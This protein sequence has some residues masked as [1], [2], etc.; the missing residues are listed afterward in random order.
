MKAGQSGNLEILRLLV[1]AG[2]ILDL[3]SKQGLTAL[4]YAVKNQNIPVAKELL[5]AGADRNARDKGGRTVV[6]LVGEQGCEEMVELFQQ[7]ALVSDTSDPF[8]QLLSTYFV[9]AEDSKASSELSPSSHESSPAASRTHTKQHLGPNT[10]PSAAPIP[11]QPL[12]KPQSDD[13]ST[14][15]DQLQKS[16]KRIADLETR[17]HDLTLQ[18]TMEPP[19]ASDLSYLDRGRL[20]EEF[21]KLKELKKKAERYAVEAKQTAQRLSAENFKLKEDLSRERHHNELTRKNMIREMEQKM[22]KSATALDRADARLEVFEQEVA[23]RALQMVRRMPAPSMALQPFRGNLK[24]M[25]PVS[26]N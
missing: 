6:E 26:L 1:A 7:Q 2:A 15:K 12:P 23:E 19:E 11:H 21:R 3:K 16:W 22:D 14:F 13:D 20:E 8:V 4:M 10:K 5:L 17:I 18:A 9:K 24:P 25:M